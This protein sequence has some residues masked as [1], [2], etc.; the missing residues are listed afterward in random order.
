MTLLIVRF[1][2]AFAVDQNNRPGLSEIR[3]TRHSLSLAVIDWLDLCNFAFNMFR[4]SVA[5][6]HQSASSIDRT[7]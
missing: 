1:H 2:E 5:I 4:Y 3:S 7:L 6:Q